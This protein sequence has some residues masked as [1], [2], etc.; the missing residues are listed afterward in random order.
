MLDE[1]GLRRRLC[2][3]VSR[4]IFRV[5]DMDGNSAS[6]DIIL[7]VVVLD[8]DMFSA[9]MDLGNSS[10]LKCTTIIFTTVAVHSCFGAAR[11]ETKLVELF[12]HFH[13]WNGCLEGHRKTNKLTFSGT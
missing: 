6:I 5:N 2:E 10:D 4:L 13:E 9:W 11:L 3:H 8:I 7:E 1:L 12:G